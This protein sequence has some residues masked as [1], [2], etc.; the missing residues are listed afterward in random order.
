MHSDDKVIAWAYD[1]PL[2]VWMYSSYNTITPHVQTSISARYVYDILQANNTNTVPQNSL[3]LL[4]QLTKYKSYLRKTRIRLY[5]FFI[6]VSFYRVFG[7]GQ[8]LPPQRLNG[9]MILINP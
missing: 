7:L 2:A 5:L 3:L 9:W 4:V 1:P 8:K 6:Y